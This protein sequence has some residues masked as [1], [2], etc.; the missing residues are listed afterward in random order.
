M[1]HEKSRPCLT[2][3]RVEN[4]KALRSLEL[5][6]LA[7]INLIGGDHGS[8]KTTLLE[9]LASLGAQIA[10][11]NLPQVIGRSAAPALAGNEAE[12]LFHF[13][14]DRPSGFQALVS[15][16]TPSLGRLELTLAL[17]QE[18]EKPDFPATAGG[19]LALETS[20]T[21]NN[22]PRFTAEYFQAG[23]KP[24]FR[25]TRQ[26][27]PLPRDYPRI[28]YVGGGKITDLG[29]LPI[30]ISSLVELGQMEEFLQNIQAVFPEVLE[31]HQTWDGQIHARTA[32]R[33]WPLSHLGGGVSLM[34]LFT[35]IILNHGG[36]AF[37]T[38]HFE[39]RLSCADLRKAWATLGRLARKYGCQLFIATHAEKDLAAVHAGLE[40]AG[41]LDDLQ[42]I[43]LERSADGA[44]RARIWGGHALEDGSP[45]D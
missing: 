15:G 23:G 14:P 33:L 9:A 45:R 19:R 18:A 43:R 44:N 26:E 36:Q 40:E 42:Y 13:D 29:V 5:P 1:D 8:G 37:V 20:L 31:I 30:L 34:A 3:V 32:D 41:A 16:Q 27:A 21:V 22:Q 11:A 12:L 2:S 10:P 25:L 38:E 7:L 4:F 39:A 6:R 17:R 35:A 28:S 24:V